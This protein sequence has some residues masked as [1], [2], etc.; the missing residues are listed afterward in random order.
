MV[1]TVLFALAVWS[2]GFG[3]LRLLGLAKG[4]LALGISPSVGL[5][6]IAIASTWMGLLQVPPP[7]PGLVLGAICL[8]GLGMVARDG[9]AIGHATTGVARQQ[10]GSAAVLC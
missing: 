1:V 3:T 4:P 2:V 10:P 7:V 5:A 8:V 9:R 6:L